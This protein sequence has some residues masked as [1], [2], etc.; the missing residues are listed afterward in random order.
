MK[1]R[2]VHQ[3]AQS[4]TRGLVFG[5]PLLFLRNSLRPV[6]RL[7]IGERAFKKMYYLTYMKLKPDGGYDHAFYEFI[8]NHNEGCYQLLADTFI[9]H[10]RPKSLVDVGCGSGGISAAFMKA[11]CADVH[12]FDYSR[13]ALERARARG[14]PDVRHIDLGEVDH[15]PAKADLC[16]CLEVAEHLPE[17]LAP[18][19]CRLLAETAP[20]LALTAAPPGQGGGHLHVNEQPQEYWIRFMQKEGMRYDK[21]AVISIRKA[22]DG[23][24]IRDYDQNLMIFRSA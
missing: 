5:A 7:L 13:A 20:I 18:K 14:L 21:E 24:M 11:G 19:L 16:I 8:E 15:I 17:S 12:S 10:F 4:V 6:V 1:A 9:A 22:Y 2:S 3:L 23:K